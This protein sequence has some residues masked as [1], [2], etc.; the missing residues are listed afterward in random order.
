VGGTPWGTTT[1]RGATATKLDAATDA[2]LEGGATL[3]PSGRAASS[4]G[5]GVAACTTVVLTAG[6][7]A[8]PAAR[9]RL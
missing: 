9:S 5:A 4:A 2:V 1:V 3:G 7:A 6:G 8:I